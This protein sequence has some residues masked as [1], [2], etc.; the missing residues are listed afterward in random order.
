M[1]REYK[2]LKKELGQRLVEL[3]KELESED[4]L[5]LAKELIKQGAEVNFNRSGPMRFATKNYNFGLIKHFISIGALS[6]PLSRSYLSGMCQRGAFDEDKEN[7]FFEII[8][9]AIAS[10]GFSKE[11]I[12]PYFKAMLL[13]G[14]VEKAKKVGERYNVP[15]KEMLEG[16]QLNVVIECLE[17]G[18]EES[19]ELINLYQDRTQEA[20]DAAVAGGR[21]KAVEYLYQNGGGADLVPDRDSVLKAI[22]N[23]YIGMLRLLDE[24]GVDMRGDWC[25][26]TA[27]RVF[28]LRR[29]PLKFL[30]ERYKDCISEEGMEALG[31]L[32][33]QENNEALREYLSEIKK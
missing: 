31:K 2:K 33:E 1:D 9:F 8:D 32:C 16:V 30:L 29:E 18:R 12:L 15:L 13:E 25:L 19:L 26:V 23:G 6:E 17:M 5:N 4:S 21:E 10:T 27:A 24:W 28:M 7:G 11:Y 3:C 22:M 20:F 14:C